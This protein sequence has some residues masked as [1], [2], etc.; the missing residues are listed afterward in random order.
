MRIALVRTCQSLPVDELA[1]PLGIMA[2]DAYLRER[3]YDD[4]HLFDMRLR[5]EAPAQLVDRVLAMQPDVVGLSA[6]TLEKDRVHEVATLLKRLAPS[7]IIVVGGPYGSSSRQAL[8]TDP[9]IDYTVVGE[10]EVTFHELLETL[11]ADGDLSTVNGIVFRSRGRVI[12]TASRAMIVDLDSLPMPSWDRI[13]MAKYSHTYHVENMTGEPWAV[14]STSRGCPFKCTYCHDVH[15]KRFRARSPQNVVDEIELLVEE[16]GIGEVLVHDD[17]FN[18]D[19]PRLLEICGLIRERGLKFHMQFPNGM[20]ADMLDE[21]MLQALRSVG[22]YRVTYAIESVTPRIQKLAKKHLNLPRVEGLLEVTD[23]LGFLMHGFFMLGFPGETREEIKA[24]IDFAV[25]SQ[26]HTAGFFLVTPFA[27]SDL[28]A[29]HP[30]WVDAAENFSYHGTPPVMAA[31]SAKELKRLQS[32]AYLR[33]YSP[34]RVVRLLWRLPKK[35]MLLS[36][37]WPF[38]RLLAGGMLPRSRRALPDA[39]QVSPAP[40]VL[41]DST[42]LAPMSRNTQRSG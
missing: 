38:L 28:A 22:T 33:F 12:E 23:R 1:Q 27:G 35:R 36:Y 5:R 24:T 6:L 2:L 19:K 11:R 4:I 37:L 32:V 34:K 13:E 14:I 9:C 42:R 20:R 39:V 29:E 30:S 10:G 31:I 40:S 21:E 3:G 17:I 18:F 25:R 26:L 41:P 15:G 7:T 8:M 16:Y